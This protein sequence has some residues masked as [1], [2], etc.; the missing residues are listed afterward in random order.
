MRSFQHWKDRGVRQVSSL[1]LCDWAEDTVEVAGFGIPVLDL[2]GDE[3]WLK[4]ARVDYYNYY[5]IMV[6]S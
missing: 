6:S 5:I 1:S 4:N 3:F 2:S